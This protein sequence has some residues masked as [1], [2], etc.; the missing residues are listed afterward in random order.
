MAYRGRGVGRGRGKDRARARARAEARTRARARARARTRAR[1]R[2]RGKGKGRGKVRGR[3]RGSLIWLTPHRLC[4]N[5]PLDVAYVA[6]K[7]IRITARINS[8]WCATISMLPSI[9]SDPRI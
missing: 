3:G 5:S 2:A 7:R 8:L 6:W 9:A 4:K 1:V